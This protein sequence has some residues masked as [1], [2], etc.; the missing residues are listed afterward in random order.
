M[1]A[2][3]WR[4]RR[5]KVDWRVPVG[6]GRG[7]MRAWI[8]WRNKPGPGHHP[9]ESE[10]ECWDN[11]WSEKWQ[12]Q[13]VR[14]GALVTLLSPSEVNTLSPPRPGA[15]GEPTWLLCGFLQASPDL[16]KDT[17]LGIVCFSCHLAEAPVST[18]ASS[19]SIYHI[20]ENTVSQFFRWIWSNRKTRA[21]ALD[22]IQLEVWWAACQPWGLNKVSQRWEHA[23][24]HVPSERL[25]LTHVQLQSTSIL[26]TINVSASCP[27]AA[28][29]CPL[30]VPGGMVLQEP[31]CA[32]P[33]WRWMAQA[34]MLNTRTASSVK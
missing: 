33:F 5:S 28:P 10:S 4:Y 25:C 19:I 29:K 1:N 21:E 2:E 12:E 14:Q 15:L 24:H 9:E 20:Q 11:V 23:F 32:A 34:L 13:Q 30:V 3:P 6:K 16:K 17:H 22:R 7:D 8:S 27:A 31:V 26:C 18:T